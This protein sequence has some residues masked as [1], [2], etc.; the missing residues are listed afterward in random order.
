MRVIR[1]GSKNGIALGS[2]CSGK[3]SAQ[4]VNELGRFHIPSGLGQCVKAIQFDRKLVVD[5]EV[6]TAHKAPTHV[7]DLFFN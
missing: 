2:Y 4:N 5:H 7:N 3:E 1:E 6:H